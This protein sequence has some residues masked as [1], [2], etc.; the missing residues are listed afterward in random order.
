MGFETQEEAERWAEN[1]ELHAA[2]KEKRLL[3]KAACCEETPCQWG[4]YPCERKKVLSQK[5]LDTDCREPCHGCELV[6]PEKR[7]SG[8]PVELALRW[9]S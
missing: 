3:H 8:C 6:A 7:C 1:M 4:D 5:T 2:A 9:L